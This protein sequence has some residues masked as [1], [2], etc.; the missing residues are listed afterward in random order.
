MCRF[1]N[2][3]TKYK[4]FL[5]IDEILYL[6]AIF[7]LRSGEL[8]SIFTSIIRSLSLKCYTTRWDWGHNRRYKYSYKFIILPYS[9]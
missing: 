7:E 1:R 8:C 4:Y 6:L 9:T 5:K 2:I 3:Y